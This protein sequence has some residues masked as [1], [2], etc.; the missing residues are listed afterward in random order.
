M[1][2]KVGNQSKDAAER[3]RRGL[4]ADHLQVLEG[5]PLTDDERA[6]FNM[7]ERENW[8]RNASDSSESRM[9]FPDNC[10]HEAA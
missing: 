4:E 3:S 9:G 8:S 7:F 6:M 10:L 5:N 2:E 1:N